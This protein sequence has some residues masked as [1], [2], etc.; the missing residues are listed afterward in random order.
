[1]NVELYQCAGDRTFLTVLNVYAPF[2]VKLDLRTEQNKMDPQ[3]LYEG[4]F[5]TQA[6]TCF[7]Q[8]SLK[9]AISHVLA[10]NSR[11]TDLMLG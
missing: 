11:A 7:L 10:K 3:H 1:M 6:V 9:A 5:W 8:L 4:D 2:L